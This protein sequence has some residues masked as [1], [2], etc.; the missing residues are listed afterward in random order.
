MSKKIVLS[1]I[2]PSGELHLGNYFGAIKNWVRLQN[3]GE[4]KCIY[5]AVDLHV[6]TMPYEPEVLK[7]KYR[8]N[9][10]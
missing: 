6:M 8:A 1:A 9:D 7:K 2:Q 4:Y 5:G 3:E 10:D